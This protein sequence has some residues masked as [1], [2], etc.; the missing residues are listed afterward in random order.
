VS[1]LSSVRTISA[2]S[3]T[4][5]LPDERGRVTGH[6]DDLAARRIGVHDPDLLGRVD[7]REHGDVRELVGELALRER[8]ERAAI[9][10]VLVRDPELARDRQRG[11]AVPGANS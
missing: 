11:L 10:G 8:G 3:R 1:N 6:R 4:T 7:A 5:S 9:E 2:T